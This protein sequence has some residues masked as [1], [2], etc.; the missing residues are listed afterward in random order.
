MSLHETIRADLLASMKARDTARTSALRMAIAALQERG[1]AD[2][3]GPQGI[4]ADE[5]VQQVLATAVKRR[6]EAAD[7]FAAAGRKDQAASEYAEAEVYEAYLPAQLSDDE[8]A[9][10]VDEVVARLGATGPGDMGQVMKSVMAELAGRA[11]GSRVSGI[12]RQRLAG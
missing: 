11:D 1:V 2:G 9:A 3:V 12:V 5:V 7:A 6:R 8:V 4:L 10:V